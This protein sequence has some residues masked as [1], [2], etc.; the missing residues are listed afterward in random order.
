MKLS[1]RMAWAAAGA[2]FALS[3][4]MAWAGNGLDSFGPAQ[5]QA[6]GG[7]GTDLTGLGTDNTIPLWN[8]TDTL[9][10]SGI[11]VTAGP[12]VDLTSSGVLS[13][14]TT[15]NDAQIA[16]VSNNR[17]A[18]RDGTGAEANMM[19]KCEGIF[20]Q[21]DNGYIT[22]NSA[23]AFN[24]SALYPGYMQVNVADG[25]G[26]DSTA[27]LYLSHTMTTDNALMPAIQ[28]WARANDGTGAAGLGVKDVDKAQNASGTTKT[29]YERDSQFVSPTNGAETSTVLWKVLQGGAQTTYLTLDGGNAQIAATKPTLA[30]SFLVNAA[31]TSGIK[32]LLDSNNHLAVKEGDASAWEQVRASVLGSMDSSNHCTAYI[33]GTNGFH[34]SVATGG[35]V[36]YSGTD[37]DAAPGAAVAAIEYYGSA[38]TLK[39]TNGGVGYGNL[40]LGQL[41]WPTGLGAATHV[42]GP[43]DQT[44]AVESGASH[45]LQ[46]NASGASN[47]IVLKVNSSTTASVSATGVNV[48]SGKV[49][50]QN[51]IETLPNLNGGRLSLSSSVAV[52]Q[53]DTTGTT[54]Y[55]LPYRDD[56]VVLYDGSDNRIVY[57]WSSVSLAVSSFPSSGTA[58]KNYD[59][60]VYDSSGLTLEAV[61]WTSDTARAT[62]ITQAG[63]M[64]VKSGTTTHRYLGT[65]RLNGNTQL[66]DSSTKRW[67]WNADNRVPCHLVKKDTTDS[68]NYTTATWRAANGDSTNSVSVVCGISE[69]L[70]DVQ[71]LSMATNGSTSDFGVGVGVDVQTANSAQL[72]TG[73]FPTTNAPL[74][75]TYR[76]VPDVGETTYY[77]I[78]WSTATGTTTWYGDVG[79]T[80]RQSGI[81]AEWER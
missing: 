37:F 70:I 39:I 81:T 40:K 74:A 38:N 25:T 1:N 44:F 59:I 22:C 76:A 20:S 10:S 72:M 18:V 5:G 8:G 28:N 68:W 24:T 27:G 53:S 45:D 41:S 46:L 42:T 69:P 61:A 35:V 6:A 19:F 3:L 52:V 9:D 50:T 23:S 26:F 60:F 47:S 65:V 16:R 48:A 34:Y 32:L 29:I 78:E 71:V 33:N 17:L 58:N 13:F 14:G 30:P 79:L 12:T 36:W 15:A 11:T 2:L 64:W 62:A 7:S 75:A 77:W 80:A 55:Y 43:T 56:R 21:S 73:Q 31:T 66:E 57:T 51:S 49:Y 63:G 67:V 54:L 4:P